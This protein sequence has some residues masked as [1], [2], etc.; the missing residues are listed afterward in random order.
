MCVCVCVCVCV[1]ICLFV[2]FVSVC[3]R[4]G[5]RARVC[6]RSCVRAFIFIVALILDSYVLLI[7]LSILCVTIGTLNVRFSPAIF[8]GLSQK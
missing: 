6:P 3:G 1:F 5:M 2:A 8:L 4:A 7:Q